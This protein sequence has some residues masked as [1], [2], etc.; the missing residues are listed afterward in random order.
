V[1]VAK[2]PQTRL[3]PKQLVV[4]PICHADKVLSGCNDFGKVLLGYGIEIK[5]NEIHVIHK[6]TYFL[7]DF[8]F[9]LK[10]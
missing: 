8:T 10:L 6:S 1:I 9:I 5:S 3:T 7:V 2:Q 4:S